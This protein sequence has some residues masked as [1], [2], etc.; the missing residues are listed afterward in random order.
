MTESINNKLG[1]DTVNDGAMYNL[2]VN[3][4]RLQELD[5]H[6]TLQEAHKRFGGSL[7]TNLAPLDSAGMQQLESEI[8]ARKYEV[9][10][11]MHGVI[12]KI[13]ATNNSLK[14]INVV[15]LREKWDKIVSHFGEKLPPEVQSLRR[16]VD[17]GLKAELEIARL[18]T[19][20][21]QAAEDNATLRDE[22]G[23]LR[24]RNTQLEN[25][26]RKQREEA[27][28][29]IRSEKGLRDQLQASQREIEGLKNAGQ[30]KD[31][32]INNLQAEIERLKRDFS[33]ASRRTKKP[34]IDEFLNEFNPEER[35]IAI[36]AMRKA[37]ARKL[38]PD[39]GGDTQRMQYIN[40]ML[41][42]LERN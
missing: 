19:E 1:E 6:K 28:R 38:H 7:L 30:K 22:N 21:A 39:A 3:L 2:K 42:G 23:V 40:A 17:P 12:A 24:S 35:N 16:D 25:D 14:G 26:A 8:N 5:V 37:L 34:T 31:V 36:G 13:P 27:S 11:F 41:D 9:A 4:V 29:R 15:N 10:K 33:S 18:K 32:Q 20:L